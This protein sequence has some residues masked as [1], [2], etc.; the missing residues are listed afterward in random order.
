MRTRFQS[1][2]A[3]VCLLAALASCER[4]PAVPIEGEG[5]AALQPGEHVSTTEDGNRM[6][7]VVQ[8]EGDVTVLLVHCWMCDRTFWSNQLPALDDHYR[9]LVIDLPGHGEA[10]ADREVWS[11]S[12]YGEDVA[13]MLEALD[14]TD[15]VLVGHSM[16]GPVSLRAAALAGE[17]VHG[18]VAVDTLHDAEFEFSSEEVQALFDAFEADFPE[19]CGN[20]VEQMFPEEGS[21]QVSTRVRETSCGKERSAVG[22]ALMSDFAGIDMPRLF[23]EAGV[24]IRAINAAGPNPTAIERNRKYADFDAVLMDDVGHY[25]HMTRPEKFNPLLLDAIAEILNESR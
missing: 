10:T 12:R 21:E 23:S 9:T 16:G 11:I 22:T 15:V 14:L 8:G 6:P 13:G 18:V 1:L 25:L 24:P 5:D 20:F 19:A 4:E 7:Y 2:V 17:R 3:T